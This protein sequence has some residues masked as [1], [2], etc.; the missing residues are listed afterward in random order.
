MLATKDKYMSMYENRDKLLKD[1]YDNQKG[2]LKG[3]M[4]SKMAE[5]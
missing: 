4:T 1:A 3:M 2:Q 5:L